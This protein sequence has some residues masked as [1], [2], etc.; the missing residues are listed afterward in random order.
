[1]ISCADL[2]RIFL[3]HFIERLANAS[4]FENILDKEQAETEEQAQLENDLKRDI[5][6]VRLILARIEKQVA[7][8]E[9][10]DVPQLLY[11]AKESYK[12]HSAELV[13]LLDRQEK[14]TKWVNLQLACVSK[15]CRSR[16][17]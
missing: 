5:N 12:L 17:R 2:D 11:A 6:A 15:D 16:S 13:R 8:G 14:I 9:L 1:M 10:A 4:D 3:E 7:S